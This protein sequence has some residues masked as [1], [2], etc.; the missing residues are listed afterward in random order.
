MTAFKEEY[1]I[2]QILK[3]YT[4]EKTVFFPKIPPTLSVY[5]FELKR[6]QFLVKLYSATIIKLEVS[7]WKTQA[8]I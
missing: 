7:F 2:S 3:E 6:L 5:L 1:I 4:K 8:Q